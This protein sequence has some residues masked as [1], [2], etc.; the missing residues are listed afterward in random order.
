[1]A[2]IS[3]PN[4]NSGKDEV[5][6]AGTEVTTASFSHDTACAFIATQYS[7][8]K[9]RYDDIVQINEDDMEEMDIKRNMALLSLR[10]DRF[11]KRTGKKIT[12]KGSDIA[13]FDK[14]KV[15]CYNCHKIGHFAR[16]CRDPRS[17][18]KDRKENSKREVKVEEAGSKAM[19]AF[20][21]NG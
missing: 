4:T 19:M 17:Q 9:V 11:W 10:A 20:D 6:T 1:M 5:S 15:E 14:S 3:S 21:G 2:F 12:I 13:R 16:E 7:G 8:S 18:E